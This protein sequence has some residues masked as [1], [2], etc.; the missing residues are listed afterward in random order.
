MTVIACVSATVVR[1]ELASSNVVVQVSSAS[2]LDQISAL[3]ARQSG[4]DASAEKSATSKS[5]L[6]LFHLSQFSVCGIK[7]L[8]KTEHDIVRPSLYAQAVL[9]VR[10]LLIQP[11]APFVL[12]S[13]SRGIF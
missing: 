12:V 13:R 1:A 5:C 4:R 10:V 6:S 11:Q 2:S 8:L 3:P 9:C 7:G